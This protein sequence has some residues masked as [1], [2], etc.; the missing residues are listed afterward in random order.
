MAIT[1]IIVLCSLLLIAYCFD[2]TSARTKIPSVILLLLLGWLVRLISD[3]IGVTLPE[4]TP[5][6]PIF[7]TI[8]LILIVLE[9]SLEL[10]L[11]SS[12]KPLIIKSFIVA[13]I[14]M[15][16][17]AFLL[18][19]VFRYFGGV[20]FKTA[21]TNAIPL[22]VISSA[23]AIPSAKNLSAYSREFVTYESSLSDIF[24]VLIFN[25]VT[26]N[27]KIGTHSFGAFLLQILIIAVVSFVSVIGLSLLLN[28]LNHHIKYVPII[29]LILL[30]YAVSKLY[31]LPALLFILVFGIFLGN[32]D[33]LKS[34]K[35]IRKLHPENMDKEVEKFKDLTVE[36]T[37]VIRALFFLLFGYLIQTS[38]LLNKETVLW[39]VSICGLII[40]L[41]SI[42]LRVSNLPVT[43]LVF[44]A[45]RG[46]ITILLF[47]SIPV[48]DRISFVN[49]SLIIQVILITAIIMMI[50]LIVTGRK[51]SD[52]KAQ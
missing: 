50:G 32:L 27:E 17:M 1:T 36:I 22:C 37:F 2:L 14:P 6:L 33:E 38:E 21:L 46:L 44:I 24:G 35:W 8:G 15:I 41:R 52:D 9:G 51:V 19:A 7:G 20:S 45:P 18:A 5:L 3:E 34:I 28:R 23:V 11:H 49:R 39:A 30:I 43:P 29:L 31:H 26:L 16:V 42:Q 13:V 48:T 47:L 10:E 25:F 4:F 40:L 12:K